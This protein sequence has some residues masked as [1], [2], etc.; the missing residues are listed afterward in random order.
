MKKMLV[1][2]AAALF[3]CGGKDSS[4]DP[5]KTTFTY[6]AGAAPTTTESSAATSGQSAALGATTLDNVS[7]GSAAG[8]LSSDSILTMP[9]D[10]GSTLMGNAGLA[11]APAPDR[12]TARTQQALAAGL[13][14]MQGTPTAD[15]IDYSTCITVTPGQI[16]YACH[17]SQT[18]NG[19]T[20]TVGLNGTL[21]RTVSSG[22]ATYV[23]DI[24]AS[25][26]E[27]DST[28]TGSASNHYTGNLAITAT[29][30]VGTSRVDLD[31]SASA[32]GVS[33]SLTVSHLA[34]VNVTYASDCITGGTLEL[35]RVW[36]KKPQYVTGVDTN[37]YGVLF[38][39][40]GCGTVT[41]AWGTQN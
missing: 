6:G 36:V 18:A 19:A 1:V 14:M 32:R 40:S 41:V 3:A 7:T 30:V 15:A 34:N 21:T 9:Q 38:T 39:W 4:V 12:L 17:D 37:N 28:G 10:L 23:W 29:T 26:S 25:L 20:T 8:S 31:A 11:Q 5:T 27:S 22:T 16:T 2:L 35:R 33:D 13:S 24:T